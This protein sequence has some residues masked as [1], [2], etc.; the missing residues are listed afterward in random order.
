MNLMINA[1]STQSHNKTEAQV[2]S[3]DEEI[4][5][6]SLRLRSCGGWWCNYRRCVLLLLGLLLGVGRTVVVN[7][8]ALHKHQQRHRFFH[9]RSSSSNDL[10]DSIEMRIKMNVA[11]QEECHDRKSWTT[12]HSVGYEQP[13]RRPEKHAK[14]NDNNYEKKNWMISINAESWSDDTRR[15]GIMTATLMIGTLFGSFPNHDAARAASLIMDNSNNNPLF[16]PNPLTNPFLEQIRIWEQAEADQL[17]YKGELERGDAGNRGKVEAYPR[18]LIPILIIAK[19]L[20]QIQDIIGK[21]NKYEAAT[22][23]LAQPKYEAIAFKKVFNRFADNIYYSD[24]DRANLYLGGGGTSCPIL[25]TI[26]SR[27]H[28]TNLKN[29]IPATPKTEQSL[30]YLLRNEILTS[31]QDLKAELAYHDQHPDDEESQRDLVAFITAAN[32]AMNQYLALVPTQE[33]ARA[34]ELLRQQ[35]LEQ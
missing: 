15:R 19:E 28:I 10:L 34:Q 17:V 24:P 27:E 22:T 18:L 12:S 11:T 1:L 29:A 21:N 33:L 30:A 6:M 32:T 31:V 25:Q 5:E 8:W 16:Q 3:K 7:A 13:Q 9:A 23:I 20:E 4:L 26:F 14:D 2:S 35:K